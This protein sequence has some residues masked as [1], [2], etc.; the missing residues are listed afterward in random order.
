MATAARL[1][2]IATAKIRKY[3]QTVTVERRDKGRGVQATSQ[4]LLCL[5]QPDRAAQLQ[6][7]AEGGK[8]AMTA[9]PH[10]FV[11]PS[12]SDVREAVDSVHYNGNVYK[13]SRVTVQMLTGSP[14]AIHAFGLREGT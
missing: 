2:A 3:G 7:L 8:N 11:F 10:R 4:T 12:G 1:A 14:V 6:M 9:D 13:I 5:P